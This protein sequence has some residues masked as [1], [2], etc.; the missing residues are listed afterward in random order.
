MTGVRIAISSEYPTVA[1]V[2][3]SATVD[4]IESGEA[5]DLYSKLS[6]RFTGGTG[7]F[8]PVR[9]TVRL[10]YDGWHS[11]SQDV[12]VLITPRTIPPAAAIEILDGRTVTLNVFRQKGNQ[13]GGT[14]L[15][16]TITEGKGNGN[17]ILE[18]GEEATI[19]VKIE[20]GMDPFDRGNWY[21]TKVHTESPWI[22]ETRDIQEQKQL[23]WTG[24]KERTSLIEMA[25]D[26]PAAAVIPLILENETWSY[27]FTP[28]VRYGKERLYQAFQ[29]H[30]RRLHRYELK[31]PVQ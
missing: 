15:P 27:H 12:D 21:R 31:V 10:D 30:D 16:R 18:P 6:A 2:R 5:I 3:G 17:G 23:E 9:F 25:R 8:A 7:Y 28:D 13:G 29:L 26:A 19:W 1:I 24:A 22:I 4:N 11:T 14:A 20:A